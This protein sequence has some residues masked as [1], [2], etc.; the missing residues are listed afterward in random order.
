M[1]RTYVGIYKSGTNAPTDRQTTSPRLLRVIDT[2]LRIA[3][4]HIADGFIVRVT[5]PTD[6]MSDMR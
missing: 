4:V 1:A 3:P 2:Q 6:T 5:S